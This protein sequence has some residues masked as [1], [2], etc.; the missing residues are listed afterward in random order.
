MRPGRA[1]TTSPWDA[2]AYGAGSDDSFV[3][4]EDHWPQ[5]AALGLSFPQRLAVNRLAL[6]FSCEMVAH[7]EQYVIDYLET[8][9]AR[10]KGSLSERA[11]LRFADDEREHVRGFLRLLRTLSGDGYRDGRL[12]Y[13][14]WTLLDR[15][16]VRL[17]PAVTFFVA[18]DLLEELFV[19]LHYVMEEQPEQSLPAARDV[20]AL[21]AREEKSHLAMDDRVIRK[22][23]EST[24]RGW[25]AV[26]AV[27]S[28]AIL[29]I[30]DF[31]TARAWRGLVRLH[32]AELGLSPVQARALERKTLSGSDV[33]GLRAFIARRTEKPFPGSRLLCWVL[34][35]PLART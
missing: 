18:A 3:A 5:F 30:V 17:A 6:C 27:M 10:L 25:F 12:R 35:R 32:A 2:I 13:L 19:H 11:A 7:F 16:V 31:K 26:Q 22:L 33:R 15:L 23:G 20:M 34:A 29:V 28:L 4:P 8:R 14:K 24:W 9:R 1:E 21:H